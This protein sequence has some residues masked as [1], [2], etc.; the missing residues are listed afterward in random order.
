MGPPDPEM[1]NRPAGDWTAILKDNLHRPINLTEAASDYQAEKLRQRCA[2]SA[3]MA[4]TLAPLVF[5][6][7]AR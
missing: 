2:I 7:A 6:E 1:R 4:E 5:L 3:A